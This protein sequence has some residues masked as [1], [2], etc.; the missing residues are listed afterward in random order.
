MN[1]DIPSD[2]DNSP[3][4]KID[5]QLAIVRRK[6]NPHCIQL[7]NSTE[8]IKYAKYYLLYDIKT[9]DGH[10]ECPQCYALILPRNSFRK[11]L[12]RYIKAEIFFGMICHEKYFAY[13]LIRRHMKLKHLKHINKVNASA[14]TEASDPNKAACS[15]KD[16]VTDIALN[17]VARRVLCTICGASVKWIEKAREYP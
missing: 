6:L 11:H 8:G 7:D 13:D 4:R 5:K 17:N 3:N 10:F 16:E 15:D 2:H 9:K 14:D 1:T 12:F